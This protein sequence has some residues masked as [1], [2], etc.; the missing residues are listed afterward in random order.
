MFLSARCSLLRAEG[1][2]CSLDALYGGL[3]VGT[4]K[5]NFFPSCKFFFI[6]GHQNPGAGSG[7]VFSLKC[8]IPI[9]IKRIRIRNTATD[10]QDLIF[11]RLGY[12]GGD[13]Q[14]V[15]AVGD[16]GHEGRQGR[17]GR[18][19]PL[20]LRLQGPVQLQQLLCLL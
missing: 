14:L 3:G 19:A 6:F 2:F 8:W 12:A 10:V 9:R 5:F 7:S 18:L 20:T 4:T 15:A 11:E 13:D 16:A 17:G 1:F